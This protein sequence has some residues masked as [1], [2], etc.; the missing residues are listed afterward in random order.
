MVFGGMCSQCVLRNSCGGGGVKYLSVSAGS[1]SSADVLSWDVPLNWTAAESGTASTLPEFVKL[2]E[3]AG[4]GSLVLLKAGTY[5]TTASLDVHGITLAG[6]FGGSTVIDANGGAYSTVVLRSGTLRDLTI[7]GGRGTLIDSTYTCGGGVLIS[8]DTEPSVIQNC[9][10]SDNQAHDMGGG[11]SVKSGNPII[12]GTTIISNKAGA[13]GGGIF[14]YSGDATVLNST[15]TLN[16]LSNDGGIDGYRGGG[17]IAVFSYAGYATGSC[18]IIS[19][20]IVSNDAGTTTGGHEICAQGNVTITGSLVWNGDTAK[21]LHTS[22]SGTFTFTKCAGSS[23]QIPAGSFD[24]V[25]TAWSPVSSSKTVRGVQHTLFRIE[26]NSPD[27]APLKEAGESTS[28][29]DQTG[30]F[31]LGSPDIGACEFREASQYYVVQ[32]SN[33]VKIYAD[34]GNYSSA[35]W[36]KASARTNLPLLMSNIFSGDVY[37]F[38]KGNYTSAQ[39]LSLTDNSRIYGGFAQTDTS[40]ASRDFTANPSLFDAAVMISADLL[41]DGIALA[42]NNASLAVSAGAKLTLR[43][44]VIDAPFGSSGRL[45]ASNDRFTSPAVLSGD[46]GIYASTFTR[47]LRTLTASITNSTIH[48]DLAGAAL[49]L[50][51]CTVKGGISGA[52]SMTNTAASSVLGLTST[53]CKVLDFSGMVSHDETAGGIVH[54]V[55][56]LEDN[57]AL[58]VLAGAGT[59]TGAPA[60]DQL[61]N[62]RRTPPYIGAIE[63]PVVSLRLLDVSLSGGNTLTLDAGTAGRLDFS[64]TVSGDYGYSY[65]KRLAEGQYTLN[66]SVSPSV[67]GITISGGT[68]SVDASASAGVYEL[69]V[70]AEAVS[71]DIKASADKDVTVMVRNIAPVLERTSYNKSVDVGTTGTLTVKASKG[72][73]IAWVMN[74]APSWVNGRASGDVEYALTFTPAREAAKQIFPLHGNSIE[75]QGQG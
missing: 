50:M 55:F 73:G 62:A 29:F 35:N 7:T 6:G 67:S 38:L 70:I 16:T 45:T 53:D 33:N 1:P 31:R 61:G 71:G 60:S 2:A 52:G 15:I 13:N 19:S 41:I 10:I 11:M 74:G 49:T 44:S 21:T 9:R 69:S 75:R 37:Y 30:N 28:S 54:S 64:A 43:N 63:G 5:T 14:V 12:T 40:L 34:S 58:V 36:A 66:W 4:S 57:D 56:R 17:G 25:I 18:D 26:D 46:T 39:T 51:N 32:D 48:G 68:L 72:T 22:D 24:K 27:L 47:N 23:D 3:V 42:G 65:V 20:T 8:D 59:S